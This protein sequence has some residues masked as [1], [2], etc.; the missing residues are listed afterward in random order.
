M[1]RVLASLLVAMCLVAAALAATP[2]DLHAEISL[3]SNF[4]APGKSLLV[5]Y[6]ITNPTDEDISILRWNTPIE[7]VKTRM[8]DIAKEDGTKPVY[9]GIMMKRVEPTR[10]HF[11]KI[12]AHSSL[13]GSVDLADVYRFDENGR[14]HM[15]LAFKGQSFQESAHWVV[16]NTAYVEVVN[17]HLN[18]VLPFYPAQLNVGYTGCSISEQ[19][20]VEAAIPQATSASLNALNYLNKD[21][22]T[23]TY[24]T[25]FGTV[26]N[27]NWNKVDNDF[28]NIHAQFVSLEF[29]INC[30]CKD[31]FTY[32]YVYPTDPTHTIHLCGAFWNAPAS[33]YQ[34]DSQPGT[35]TH[36]MSHFNDIAGTDD[37]VYGTSGCQA[38]AIS[39]P[40]EAIDNADSHEYFQESKPTC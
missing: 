7:G 22:C 29:N 3:S 33:P 8:F 18:D 35:L 38:L 26:T 39:N 14:Y 23:S 34:Y 4:Y 2:A 17:V 6:T 27:S 15:R 5:S 31:P 13:E 37:I 40:N 28:T 12:A 21:Q 36:E 30:Q 19:N 9:A 25:W 32:A 10:G 1:A 16:S 11:V 20:I 24:V